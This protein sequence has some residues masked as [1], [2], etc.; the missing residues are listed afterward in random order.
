MKSAKACPNIKATAV[1]YDFSDLKDRLKVLGFKAK[2]SQN[3]ITVEFDD[4]SQVEEFFE[5]FSS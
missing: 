1:S 3:K 4:E 2:S 5:Y